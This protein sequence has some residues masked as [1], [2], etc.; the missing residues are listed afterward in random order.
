MITVLYV[1]DEPALLGLTKHYLERTGDFFIHTADSGRCALELLEEK[2]FDG[3]ISD[4]E[5]PE[6]DGLTLLKNVRTKWPHIP[7]LVFT[8]RGREDVVIQAYELGADFYIQKGGEPHAQFT[9]L[10]HKIKEA[11]SRRQINEAFR[12]SEERFSKAFSLTPIA[13]SIFELPDRRLVDVNQTFTRL[14]GYSREEV[15][16]KTLDKLGFGIHPDVTEKIHATLEKGQNIRNQNIEFLTKDGTKKFGLL[17]ADTVSIGQK[18]YVL[19]CTLDISWQKHHDEELR[20]RDAILNSV[21][22]SAG[23]LLRA[24]DPDTA[25]PS[26]L[27]NLGRTFGAN[28]IYIYLM[29]GPQDR[30]LAR[31]HYEW[32]PEG[33]ESWKK[34]P[35]R[36]LVDY[37]GAGYLDLETRLMK[38]G[39]IVQ[40]ITNT[41]PHGR[42]PSENDGI[43]MALFP[44]RITSDIQ[45]VVGFEADPCRVWFKGELDA[46]RT[47]AALVGSAIQNADMRRTLCERERNYETLIR[48]SPDGICLTDMQG[49][50]TYASE[51]ALTLF[52]LTA[53]DEA[54]GTSIFEWIAPEMRSEAI[55][56]VRKFFSVSNVP[57]ALGEYHLVRKDGSRFYAEISSAVQT[58]NAG[59]PIGMLSLLRDVTDKVRIREDVLRSEELHR[60]L[61]EN[62]PDAILII[63]LPE[64]IVSVSRNVCELVGAASDSAILG[65]VISDWTLPADHAKLRE[66]IE[67]LIQTKT[68]QD[69]TLEIY[70]TDNTRFFADINSSVLL[71]SS[72]KPTR[73]IAHIRDI[74]QRVETEEALRH[75]NNRLNL[76]SSITCHD[77]KNK[78]LVI[79]G[80]LGLLNETKSTYLSKIEDS[81]SVMQKHLDFIENYENL[82]MSSPKWQ[83]AE[84]SFIQVLSQVDTGTVKVKNR[85]KGLSIYADPLFQKVL[86]NL[87]DNAI[88][89]GGPN[90]SEIQVAYYGNGDSCVISLEDNGTGIPPEQKERIFERGVGKGTGLG[91]FLV[92]EILSITGISIR[93]TGA[94]GKGSRFEI[95]IPPDKFR[96]F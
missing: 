31:L 67:K 34:Y 93:E 38:E 86:Y 92:K 33:I 68:P 65:T 51:S 96:I 62:S 42:S 26:V 85:L 24:N 91:L 94:F 44:I 53:P 32:V 21:V 61:F 46:L 11:V 77:L 18:K 8:G 13:M 82:G 16:G 72:G 12:A 63:E 36:C 20:R 41:S 22:D 76:L 66:Y 2:T 50:I 7:F 83:D 4:Y 80:Y 88:R 9:E 14:M 60:A 64:T 71:D 39:M 79:K 35:H 59:K 89:Y 84:Y 29:E 54:L 30:P 23:S 27:E 75:A 52:H 5:M 3:I 6:M 74:S 78:I 48:T 70:R 19:T 81:V 69:I 49:N 57:K 10:I 37:R 95:T 56:R 55:D 28:R 73:I 43:S 47:A 1:D 40:T 58:D 25:I 87:M 17:S 15:V 45:G 90:L